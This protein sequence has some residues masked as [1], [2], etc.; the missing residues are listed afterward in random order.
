[1]RLPTTDFRPYL[2]PTY[3]VDSDSPAVI[4]FAQTTAAG[5]QTDIEKA[6]KLYY[7]VRDQIRYRIYGIVFEPYW[8]KASTALAEKVSF[9]MPKAALLAAAAR[10]LGIPSRLGFADVR[11]HLSTGRLL[12]LMRTDVFIYHG[13]TE[14]FL[15]GRW[16][17]ATPAFNLSLCQKFGVLP[18][19]FDGQHDSL[20]HAFDAQGQQH[21]EYLRDHGHFADLPFEQVMAALAE[22]YPH[23][24]GPHGSGWPDGD[25]EREAI[26]N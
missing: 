13:Y 12:D 21:M 1:M 19:E 24:L 26:R 5:G 3:F 10:V 9:C 8:F 6:V 22:G 18:L 15:A 16:V 17:K 7:A 23:L 2:Q 4:E 20:F 25:F 11:N 14:L